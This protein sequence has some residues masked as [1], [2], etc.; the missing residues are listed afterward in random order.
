MK[1]L[2][3][4]LLIHIAL[5]QAQAAILTTIPSAMTQ[6]GMIHINVTFLDQAS[7]TFSSNVESGTPQ[8]K[9]LALWSPGNN[10]DAMSPWYM[11]LDP[12]QEARQYSNR[13]GFLVDTGASSLIPGGKSLGIRMLSSMPGLGAYFYNTSGNGTFAPV[14][15]TSGSAHDYV[16]WNG[17]MWHTVFTMPASTPYGTP[18]SA[19][20]EFFLADSAA[21][22]AV[23]YTTTASAAAGYST[24]TQT[25]SWTAIPEPSAWVLLLS[26][27]VVAAVLRRR[28][29]A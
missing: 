15:L 5:M 4:F 25:V 3:T 20:F 13:F 10:F 26:A 28:N 21:G 8:M 16:L 2:F 1:K 14:F 24:T 18:V 7:G 17:T 9:P 22:S 19:T 12:T 11:T 6:G 23:D 27:G 29:I